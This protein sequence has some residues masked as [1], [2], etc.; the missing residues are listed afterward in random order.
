MDEVIDAIASLLEVDMNGWLAGVLGVGVLALLFSAWLQMRIKGYDP[1]S[2]KM[3]KRMMRQ[4]SFFLL[5]DIMVGVVHMLRRDGNL[6][7]PG[8][9]AQ[10]WKF[11]F[12]RNGVLRRIW[13]AYREYFR[14][15][16]HPWQRD[17]RELLATWKSSQE[18]L[19]AL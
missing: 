7:S 10:G 14:D 9:W 12:F 2:E 16:F 17:T 5:L 8:L 6:W 11:L 1:G 4:A 15:G 13:P 3:R 18:A 19:A